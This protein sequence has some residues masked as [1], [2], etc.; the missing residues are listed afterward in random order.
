MVYFRWRTATVGT[1]QYWHGI[2]PHDG[3]PG[4]RYQEIA[5][6]GRELQRVGDL[7]TADLPTEVA[8]LRSYETLWAFEAQPTAQHL[9]YDDQIKRYYRA[10]WRRNVA[11]DVVTEQQS[12]E[13]YRVL[14]VPCLFVMRDEVAARLAAYVQEGG[15]LVL[16]FRSGVKDESNRIAAGSLP[17]L[18]SDLAGVRVADYTALLSYGAGVPAGGPE[19][20]ELT[21]DAVSQRVSADV[22]MDDL[23][24]RDAEVLGTYRGGIYDGRPAVTVRQVGKGSVIYVGTALDAS[25]LDL[26]VGHILTRADIT[27][28]VPAPANVEIVHRVHNGVDHWFVLNHNADECSVTLPTGGIDLLTG[29]EVSGTISVQGYDVLV[30]QRGQ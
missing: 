27:S 21:F 1:E 14:I 22:W 26:L 20:L 25:G 15:T 18:L 5:R 3:I 10:L 13:A 2:L 12:W 30:V 28:G 19:A 4:R 17:G 24:C 29:K 23:E 16:T 11:V 7:V 8:L 9:S 6:T